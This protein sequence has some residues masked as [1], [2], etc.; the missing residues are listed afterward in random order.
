MPVIQVLGGT[1]F[2]AGAIG[3]VWRTQTWIGDINGDSLVNIADVEGFVN[4]LLGYD[5]N[6][7]LFGTADVN[8]DS[9]ANGLDVAP[10][11]AMVRNG[12]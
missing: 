2:Q 10:F 11:V 8:R 12:P 1:G 4:V 3:T 5:S 7:C 9:I 6:L